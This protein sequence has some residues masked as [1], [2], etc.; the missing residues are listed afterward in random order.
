M[1]Q[2]FYDI[3]MDEGQKKEGRNWAYCL[4]RAA[5]ILRAVEENP[6]SKSILTRKKGSC[7]EKEELKCPPELRNISIFVDHAE[8]LDRNDRAEALVLAYYCRVYA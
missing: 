4:R 8:K 6:K 5:E 2:Q 3:S 7:G 1:I